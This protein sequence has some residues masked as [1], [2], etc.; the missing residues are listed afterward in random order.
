MVGVQGALLLHRAWEHSRTG[1]GGGE[2]RAGWELGEELGDPASRRAFRAG[3]RAA[4]EL[5][6]PLWTNISD[7]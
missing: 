7:G 3:G 6:S 2:C 1:S 4:I 5:G